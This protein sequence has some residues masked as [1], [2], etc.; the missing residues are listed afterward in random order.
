MAAAAAVVAAAAAAAVV[1]AAVVVVIVAHTHSPKELLPLSVA[2]RVFFAHPFV[3][4]LQK[5][6]AAA[7]SLQR[8]AALKAEQPRGFAHV[9]LCVIGRDL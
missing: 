5:Q 2:V 8:K 7:S 4:D 3:R 1:V 6:V 9:Y